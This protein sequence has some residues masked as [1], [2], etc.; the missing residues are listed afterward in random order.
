MITKTVLISGAGIAGPT[1]A[2]WL[3]QYG[4]EP[5]IVERSPAL[6][7]GGY[8]IDFWGLGFDVAE[9]MGLLPALHQTGYRAEELRLV[10]SR[11]KKVG[12]FTTSIFQSN[13]GD[14]FLS[15]LR[16]DLASVIFRAISDEVEIMFGNTIN[17]I[18]QDEQ[19][20]VVSFQTGIPRR[21]DLVIGCD[22]LHST[23]R[24]ITFG[25][26][27]QFEKK[28]GYYVAAFS[29]DN[30]RPRDEGAYVAY[31][32]PGMQIARYALRDDRT[33]FFLIFSSKGDAEITTRNEQFEMLN[34]VL[35]SGKWECQSIRNALG[36]CT[37]LYF[38]RVSQIV[39]P[40]WSKG[41]VA[42]VGDAAYCPSLLAGQGAALAMAGS[43]I[44]AGELSQAGDDYSGA[45]KMYEDR[46]KS[47]IGKKQAG[48]ARFGAWFAPQTEFGIFLRN[49]ITR[50]FA[51]R[52]IADKFVKDSIADELTLPS[53][54]Q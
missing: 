50:L 44:L 9:Q 3:L 31:S 25:S 47:F 21:F 34:E 27:D 48:A 32:L 19:G 46:L 11:G 20:V 6:R 26:E 24:S 18:E 35:A 40:A 2:Y 5:T 52:F 51:I 38:D 53:Y 37:D 28:L 15:I 22:G 23:V 8:V 49:Q 45:F 41:R 29:T 7:E 30:Y 39:M 17:S 33:V 36:T 16:G 42:L 43:Y 14:R 4:F 12:G 54:N 1:L 10:N 13:L